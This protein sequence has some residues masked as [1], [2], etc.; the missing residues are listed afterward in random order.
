[1]FRNCVPTRPRRIDDVA[2]AKNLGDIVG[3]K[4]VAGSRCLAI[5]LQSLFRMS[6]VSDAK[7]SISF[8]ACDTLC[9]PPSFERVYSGASRRA[10]R[11]GD[12]HRISARGGNEL[13]KQRSLRYE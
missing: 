11:A 2:V 6:Q 10:L 7:Y 12:G 9:R 3:R 5:P 8:D 1:M 13:S 4:S